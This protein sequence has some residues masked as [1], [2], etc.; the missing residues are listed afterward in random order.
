MKLYDDSKTTEFTAAVTFCG[1]DEV[2]IYVLLDR[3]FFFPEGGG[4]CSD[5]GTIG[6]VDCM[7]IKEIYHECRHYIA[8]QIAPGTV[9]NCKIDMKTRRRNMEHHSGEHIIS[10]IIHKK[11]GYSNIGFHLG[12]SDVTC[13]FDGEF[14]GDDVRAIEEEANR[15]VR[16]NTKVN[17]FYLSDSE[18][19]ALDYRSKSEISGDVRL[20]E[21][22]GYDLCACC[23]PHVLTTGEIG[24]IKI[25]DHEKWKGGTRLH[26]K[27]GADAFADYSRKH[28]QN[29]EIS[30]L[31]CVPS[32]KTAEGVKKALASSE[33]K[34]RVIYELSLRIAEL[35]ISEIA[36]SEHSI[37]I[38]EDMLTQDSMR[39]IVNEC[40]PRTNEICI[41]LS[42]C[43]NGYTF[44][45]KSIKV[46]LREFVSNAKERISIKGGGSNNFALGQI[47]E[48]RATIEE[49]FANWRKE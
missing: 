24:L 45:M 42:K 35:R 19:G 6:D 34:D 47:F 40:A 20:V 25:V 38:F 10:G 15:V 30:S 14:S 22:S 21:I 48:S 13:D 33:E 39:R 17:V 28:E 23:A 41:V 5:H 36:Q 26:L 3:T 32:D 44:M 46:P 31:I 8:A 9:C 11:F 18:L 1:C 7:M 37:V 2:G 43:Q 4:Q 49:Y 12:T 16:E 29:K 27:C